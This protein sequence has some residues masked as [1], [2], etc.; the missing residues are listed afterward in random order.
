MLDFQESYDRAVKILTS[1]RNVLDRVAKALLKYETLDQ[2]EFIDVV[3]GKSIRSAP[4][5]KEQKTPTKDA[6]L[7]KKLEGDDQPKPFPQFT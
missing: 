7:K 6:E 1:H 2:Q 5:G 3:N 4:S